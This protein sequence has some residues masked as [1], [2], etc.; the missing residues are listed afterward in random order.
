MLVSLHKQRGHE[1]KDCDL[2]SWGSKDTQPPP[3]LA[4]LGR[5]QSPHGSKPGRLPGLA[6]CLILSLPVEGV[7]PAVSSATPGPCNRTLGVC[8]GLRRQGQAQSGSTTS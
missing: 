5:L 8:E 6:L 7:A 2:R 3:G 1:G 4:P